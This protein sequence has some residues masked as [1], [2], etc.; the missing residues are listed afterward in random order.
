ML[1]LFFFGPMLER[2]WGGRKFLIFYLV[3]GAM[4]G[5][6]YTLLV[7]VRFL[8]VPLPLIG[9]SGAILGTIAATAIMFPRARV[10]VWGIFPMPL[11]V[12]AGLL[13]LFSILTL[14]S[15]DERINA[16]GEAAHLAGMAAGAIYVLYRPWRNRLKLKT[17]T[18][19]WEKNITRQRDLQLEL[20][21]ILE[22]V[23][24]SGIHSLTSKEKRILRK[25]TE[26]ERK[27][28]GL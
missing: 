1:G 10:Y 20:D 7:L 2:M 3:C 16:G 11:I 26:A 24:N 22:K 17:Q 14:I 8:S 18:E 28:S 5:I 27:R 12:L 23:H 19:Q 4:G 21:R 9:A 15:P 6:L 13:A 25:A